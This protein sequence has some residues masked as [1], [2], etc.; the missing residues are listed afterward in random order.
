M[1]A[2]GNCRPAAFEVLFFQVKWGNFSS[3]RKGKERLLHPTP[4]PHPLTP[5]DSQTDWPRGVGNATHAH[6]T[7][8]NAG[9][10]LFGC[11]ERKC[12]NVLFTVQARR[13][14]GTFP[15]D[16]LLLTTQAQH[17][18]INLTLRFES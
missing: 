6:T 10:K 16:P 7:F 13:R 4:P 2:L 3:G 18:K 9:N 8:S 1:P 12:S 17:I 14:N 11:F 15:V 5:Q